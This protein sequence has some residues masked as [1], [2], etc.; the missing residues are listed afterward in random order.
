MAGRRG[1]DDV[2]RRVQ[3]QVRVDLRVDHRVLREARRDLAAERRGVARV[4]VDGCRRRQWRQRR[5]R[6]A[7]SRGASREHRGPA[8]SGARRLRRGRRHREVGG[9]R[10]AQR[11]HDVAV[12]SAEPEADRHE[13]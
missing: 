4:Q 9:A 10:H 12:D 2:S 13:R 3:R 5:R 11:R 1:G 7:L 8:A 6:Q